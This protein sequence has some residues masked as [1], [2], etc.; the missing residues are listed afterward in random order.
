MSG[1]P[2]LARFLTEL[3]DRRRRLESLVDA[4][5]GEV[6]DEVR[7]ASNQLLAAREELRVQQQELEAAQLAALLT[8][9]EYDRAFVDEALPCLRTDHHGLIVETNSAAR[10]LLTWPLVS[11]SRRPLAVHFT[12]A[13][14]VIVRSMISRA[15]RQAGHLTGDATVQRS[16]GRQTPVRLAVAANAPPKGDLRWAALRLDGEWNQPN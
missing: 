2:E 10:E 6:R 5:S 11:W 13:T 3:D 15:G 9:A 12:L 4:E 7:A 14:R 8:G 1:R 16:I